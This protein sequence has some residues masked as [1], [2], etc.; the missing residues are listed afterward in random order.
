MYHYHRLKI[1][2]PVLNRHDKTVLSKHSL[3]SSEGGNPQD[4]LH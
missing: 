1:V 2:F 4:F 3:L